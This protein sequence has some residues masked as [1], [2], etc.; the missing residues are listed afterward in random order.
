MEGAIKKSSKVAVL[1]EVKPKK[2][3]FDEYL[4]LAAVLKAELEKAEG[5]ISMERFSSLN[6]EGK[7]L[8][9]S[10]WESEEA[11]EKWRN[12]ASHRTCQKKGHDALFAEYKISVMSVIR[13]Y[14]N[15]GRE[16]APQDSN[17]FLGVK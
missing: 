5:L 3:G 1:F 13:E 17:A 10:V 7:L 6:E 14:T 16:Q 2:D 8:S 15:E 9:L 4:R 11:A 12:R